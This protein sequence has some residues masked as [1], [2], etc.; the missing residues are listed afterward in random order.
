MGLEIADAD[1]DADADAG[2]D[3]DAVVEYG[4]GCDMVNQTNEQRARWT[5]D[6]VKH[7]YCIVVVA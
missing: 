7:E 2:A 6:L 5:L 3:A 1:A 4:W